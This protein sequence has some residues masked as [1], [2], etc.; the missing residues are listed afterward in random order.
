MADMIDMAET[1]KRK[2]VAHDTSPAIIR[3]HAF[4]PRG[5]WWTLCKI[6][7]LAEAAHTET[8]ID[9]DEIKQIAY[10]SDDDPDDT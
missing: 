7:S 9:H 3:D 5:E 8:T 1:P 2:V 6:C 10:Y 4:E